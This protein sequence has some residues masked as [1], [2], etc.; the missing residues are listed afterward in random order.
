MNYLKVAACLILVLS[1]APQSLA[2]VYTWTDE[3]GVKHYSNVAPPDAATELRKDDEIPSEP[4]AS[5][6][7]SDPVESDE[8]PEQSP[9]QTDDKIDK[10]PKAILDELR[11][12]KKA[13]EKSAPSVE[14]SVPDS[15]QSLSQGDIVANEKAH[16]KQL[17]T[18]LENDPG[19]RDAFIN[20][21]KDRLMQTLETARQMPT[22]QFGSSRNKSR[23]LGYY[24]YRLNELENNPDTYFNYGDSDSD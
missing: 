8:P 13:V 4:S 2:Q 17:Q 3:K 22:S 5:S 7:A 6:P 1:L 15:N 18:E 21:E 20:S 19:K 12:S 10:N 24:E 11:S 23:R 9:P 16:V 14:E